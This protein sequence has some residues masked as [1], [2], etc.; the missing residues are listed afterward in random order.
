MS[1]SDKLMKWNVSGLQGALL[2]YFIEPL[3]LA[4]VTVEYRYDANSMARAMAGRVLFFEPNH[5]YKVNQPYLSFVS[6]KGDRI[7]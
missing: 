3:Y 1:S 4:S 7:E 2:G 6:L 5:P